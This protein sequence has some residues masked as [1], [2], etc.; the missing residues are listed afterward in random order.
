MVDSS[1]DAEL[2]PSLDPEAFLIS[3]KKK[4]GAIHFQKE[5]DQET[6]MVT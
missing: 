6:R 4:S 3:E 2:Q 5:F 1:S